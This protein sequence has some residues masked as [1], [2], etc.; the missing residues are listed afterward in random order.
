MRISASPPQARVARF[1]I[2]RPR[3]RLT[4]LAEEADGI[5]ERVGLWDR[6]DRLAGTLAHGEQRALEIGM[7]LA[8]VR[9]CCCWTSRPPA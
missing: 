8:A 1:D 3:A 6:R 5:L 4:Q 2:W 7:A 9:G